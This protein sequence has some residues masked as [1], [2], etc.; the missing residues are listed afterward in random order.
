MK[1][2]AFAVAALLVGAHVAAGASPEGTTFYLQLIQGTDADT[3]PVT[4]ATLVGD[5]LGHRLE[6]FRWKN[7]WEVKRQTVQLKTGAK[8][9]RPMTHRRDVEIAL[10]TPT[11]MTVC[12]YT[13]GKLTRKRAQPIET[14]F[15]IAGGDNDEAQSWF[16]VVRR[17]K[18]G[19]A[20]AKT[21]A[22]ST[23]G[24]PHQRPFRQ[25]VVEGQQVVGG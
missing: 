11:D 14:S 4:G 3:P 1:A 15:Y 21:E 2:M 7:Y 6:M 18:P 8:I 12:I 25:L 9:R 13:D 19:N 22:Q 23:L 24:D 10:M 16:I 5:A 20:P 17:D